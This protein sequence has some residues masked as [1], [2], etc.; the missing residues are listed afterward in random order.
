[1]LPQ[2]KVKKMKFTVTQLVRGIMGVSPIFIVIIHLEGIRKLLRVVIVGTVKAMWILG[3]MALGEVK[4]RA[5][6]HM[7]LIGWRG[8]GW[9]I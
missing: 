9:E 1:V 8:K 3:E 4:G 7:V 2:L 5:K 6:R